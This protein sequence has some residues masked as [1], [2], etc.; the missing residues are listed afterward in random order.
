M[1]TISGHYDGNVVILDEP[2]PVQGTAQVEVTFSEEA[3]ALAEGAGEGRSLRWYWDHAE[4]AVRRA[5]EIASTRRMLPG[6]G[7][8]AVNTLPD[9][10]ASDEEWEA[11][12]RRIGELFAR[13]KAEEPSEDLAT[14]EEL[15]EGLRRNPVRMREVRLDE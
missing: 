13:W 14:N 10:T 11:R 5:T 2:A 12:A 6:I 7:P 15:H 8:E 3:E 4:E 1:K 9:F